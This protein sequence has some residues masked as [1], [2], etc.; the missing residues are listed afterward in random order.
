MVVQGIALFKGDV[1]SPVAD[2]DI[3]LKTRDESQWSGELVADTDVLGC[4]SWDF[5][6]WSVLELGASFHWK[7][8]DSLW[9]GN[10][11]V[12]EDVAVG[13]LYIGLLF[14]GGVGGWPVGRELVDEVLWVG[15][16]DGCWEWAEGGEEGVADSE[17]LCG[18]WSEWLWKMD[19]VELS[20]AEWL[21][22]VY[23]FDMGRSYLVPSVAAT[24]TWKGGNEA[25]FL[26]LA[27]STPNFSA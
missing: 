21:A 14:Q 8:G 22:F 2:L 11:C 18:L 10:L 5:A 3:T 4:A 24:S 27:S 6:K 15:L 7:L 19:L 23:T 25:S 12:F 9:I 20:R 13:E 26:S 1:S 16:E 17:G